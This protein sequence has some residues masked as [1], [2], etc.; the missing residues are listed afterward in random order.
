MACLNFDS[1]SLL[2]LFWNFGQTGI[3]NH[4]AFAGVLD[5]VQKAAMS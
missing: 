2:F 1:C 4:E 5:K 3:E